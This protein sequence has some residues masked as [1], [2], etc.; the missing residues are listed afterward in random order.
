MA[1]LLNQLFFVL[2]FGVDKTRIYMRII[3]D[4]LFSA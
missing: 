4:Y 3:M 1:K 2:D